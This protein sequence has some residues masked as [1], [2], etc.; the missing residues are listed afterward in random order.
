[1]KDSAPPQGVTAQESAT[2]ADLWCLALTDDPQAFGVI[3]TDTS[4]RST[5]SVPDA[6]D[7]P[8]ARTIWSPSCSS[9]RGAVDTASCSSKAG[10]RRGCMPSLGIQW[11]TALAANSD[12]EK[13]SPA[14]P[15][16]GDASTFVPR[17]ARPGPA[18]S[19][20]CAI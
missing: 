8:I 7:Q 17:H 1:M 10:C 15:S 12:I 6:P 4:S 18:R 2:D 16:T 3:L 9:K 13:H 11:P 5:D 14:Y 20:T 19:C